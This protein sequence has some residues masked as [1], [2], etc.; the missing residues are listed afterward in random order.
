M[1][2][3]AGE[4][5]GGGERGR[6]GPPGARRRTGGGVAGLVGAP[7]APPAG[8]AAPEGG[9]GGGGVKVTVGCGSVG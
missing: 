2:R 6:A 5:A 8:P 7:P 4:P 1:K 3:G 9:G